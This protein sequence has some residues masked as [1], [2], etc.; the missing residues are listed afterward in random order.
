VV[1]QSEE[2]LFLA[3]E[4]DIFPERVCVVRVGGVEVD[5][6]VLNGLQVVNSVGVSPEPSIIV[7]KF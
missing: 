4:A 5:K 2:S 7:G 1:K 3:N 6:D